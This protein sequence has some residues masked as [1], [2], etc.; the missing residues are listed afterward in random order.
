[1]ATNGPCSE[2]YHRDN[3][4]VAEF[5]A[6][7][8]NGVA[9]LRGDRNRGDLFSIT[10]AVGFAA[11]ICPQIAEAQRTPEARAIA[12]SADSAEADAGCALPSEPWGVPA[13]LDAAITGSADKDRACMKALLIPDARITLVSSVRTERQAT[14]S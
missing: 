9:S 6:L 10:A 11:T 8:Q 1:M 7:Q 5:S 3:N 4:E 13:A 12:E 2:H 14:S